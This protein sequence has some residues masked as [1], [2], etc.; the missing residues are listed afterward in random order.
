[1]ILYCSGRY[2][3]LLLLLGPYKS[4]WIFPSSTGSHSSGSSSVFTGAFVAEE[5]DAVGDNG[6]GDTTMADVHYIYSWRL[7]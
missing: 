2:F 3:F 5:D 7:I 4:V 1:M 6:S